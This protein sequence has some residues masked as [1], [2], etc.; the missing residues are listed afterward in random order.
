MA[1]M[2]ISEITGSLLMKASA[3]VE[4]ALMEPCTLASSLARSKFKMPAVRASSATASLF[5][6]ALAF[7]ACAFTFKMPITRA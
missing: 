6:G 5:T 7:S 4:A 2:E 3:L 1:G